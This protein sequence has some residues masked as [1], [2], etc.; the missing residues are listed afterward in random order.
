M[1]VGEAEAGLVGGEGEF[2]GG[3]VFSDVLGGYEEIAV[4]GLFEP[5]LDG[6][7]EVV[8]GQRGDGVGYGVAT[9]KKPAVSWLVTV[10]WRLPFPCP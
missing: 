7:P 2:E 8:L 6:G 10:E 4:A 3:M 9:C 5:V 1:F